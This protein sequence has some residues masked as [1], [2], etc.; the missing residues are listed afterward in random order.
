MTAS[1][2][3]AA[4]TRRFAEELKE[5]RTAAGIT[6]CRSL[7]TLANYNRTSIAAAEAG[8]RLPSLDVTLAIVK[9]CAGSERDWESIKEDWEARWRR[10]FAAVNCPGKGL[11]AASPW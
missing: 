4:V 10:A 9:A 2:E 8:R 5:L 3:H 6:S 1:P 7:A 11:V